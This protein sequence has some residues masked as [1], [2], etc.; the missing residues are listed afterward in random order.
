MIVYFDT[1]AF[2][3][4]VVAEPGS[5]IAVRAWTDA[6]Q[7]AACRLLYPEARA[8][9]AQ[10]RRMGRLPARSLGASRRTLEALWAD[11][12]VVEI[13][14]QV[15]QAAGDAAEQ[16]GLRGYDAVH[17]VSALHTNA[18]VLVCADTDL[19]RAAH[20]CGLAVVDARS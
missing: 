16:Q 8:G 17:L 13:T 2:L 6:D 7:V 1:S 20:A 18:D 11:V 3:K 4:L 14:P 9:L 10:A 15:A 5:V 19:L 12:E